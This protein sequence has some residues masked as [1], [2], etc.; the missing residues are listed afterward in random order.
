MDEQQGPTIE[1]SHELLLNYTQY[2]VITYKE[3]QS[4]KQL[5]IVHQLYFNKNRN[6]WNR[7]RDNILGAPKSLQMVI[8]AMK[9]KDAYSLEGKL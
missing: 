5:N 3:K 9:L 6:I 8:A 2:F 4:R 7:V 1:H